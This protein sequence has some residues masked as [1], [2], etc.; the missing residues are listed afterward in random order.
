MNKNFFQI[1][2]SVCSGTEYFLQLF[3]VSIYK[4]IFHLFLLSLLCGGFIAI[5]Q[6]IIESKNLKNY[7]VLFENTFG[8]VNIS[9]KG[10]IPSKEITTIKKIANKKFLI[11]HIPNNEIL[12]D[13]N[14]DDFKGGVIWKSNLVLSWSK[15]T[16][17]QV[18][19]NPILMYSQGNQDKALP[20]SISLSKTKFINLINKDIIEIAKIPEIFHDNYSFSY[21]Y[22]ITFFFISTFAFNAFIIFM[23]C[24]VYTLMFA[25]FFIMPASERKMKFPNIFVLGIYMG[26]PGIIIAS[27]FPAF[28][29]PFLEYPS[30]YAISFLIYSFPVIARLREVLK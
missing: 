13:I 10:I 19:F 4:G 26:F 8:E 27:C 9:D 15:M 24:L 21:F 29:L 12:K 5:S 14:L 7:T 1:I 6:T 18:Q 20:M 2:L 17:T 22:L 16:K 28:K 23:V 30:V 3:K 25:I 11:I